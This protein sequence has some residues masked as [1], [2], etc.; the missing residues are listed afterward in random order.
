V[1]QGETTL[2]KIS[3]QRLLDAWQRGLDDFLG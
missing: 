2:C 1:S 3:R